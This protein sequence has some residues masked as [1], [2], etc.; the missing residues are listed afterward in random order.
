[1]H[2]ANASQ[3]R[4]AEFLDVPCTF[5]CLHKPFIVGIAEA[6]F[7]VLIVLPH[8]QPRLKRDLDKQELD[9]REVRDLQLA[10]CLGL[11]LL[12]QLAVVAGL[13]ATED[14][15]RRWVRQDLVDEQWPGC[16]LRTQPQAQ[17]AG[18]VVLGHLN[19][20]VFLAPR[21]G[22]HWRLGRRLVCGTHGRPLSS[23]AAPRLPA[24]AS[25]A[26]VP[27]PQSYVAG[28]RSDRRGAQRR[29]RRLSCA[30]NGPIGKTHAYVYRPAR[31]LRPS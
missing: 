2:R 29:R 3:R 20:L 22:R 31:P 19:L 4:V 16:Y 28:D 12:N 18:A 13:D 10:P 23:A 27:S 9:K 21:L 17:S 30:F 1:M 26:A 11:V 6:D 25:H 15:D 8:F 24:A 7:T 14:V 5:K